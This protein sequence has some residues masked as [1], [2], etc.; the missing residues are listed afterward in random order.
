M[1]L[2]AFPFLSGLHEDQ[3]HLVHTTFIEELMFWTLKFE[4][5]Q[6][7]VTLLLSIF[8][9]AQIDRHVDPYF[10]PEACLFLRI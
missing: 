8:D 4:F 6:K 7:V 3:S 9:M 10:C 1:Y 5:P 2:Y